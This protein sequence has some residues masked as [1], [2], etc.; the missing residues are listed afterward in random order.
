[1]VCALSSFVLLACTFH[2]TSADDEVVPTCPNP[3]PL[4]KAEAAEP[5]KLIVTLKEN[6]SADDFARRVASQEVTISSKVRR[7]RMVGIS[8]TPQA[9]ARLRCDI[10]VKSISPVE[11][12][13]AD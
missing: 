7:L 2:N 4:G 10:D 9:V 5:G 8:A 1:M 3:A 13:I 6:V 12:T 11:P